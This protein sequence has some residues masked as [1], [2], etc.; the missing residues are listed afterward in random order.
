MP[1]AAEDGVE[2]FILIH[3]V[4]AAIAEAFPPCPTA[5]TV[6]Y[7]R[8]GR[9]FGKPDQI[10]D[11]LKKLMLDLGHYA[12][13]EI[14]GET[15]RETDY[16]FHGLRKLAACHLAE[17]NATPHEIGAIC[18][19]DIQTVTKYTRGVAKRKLAR[20]TASRMN[21]IRPGQSRPDQR[22]GA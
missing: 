17:V 3:P 20:G 21:T 4:L 5:T 10:Q 22:L 13:V 6:L 11:R 9:P 2:V 12:E 14:D 16:K 15:K 19:M 7:N 18:G 8:V 1:G